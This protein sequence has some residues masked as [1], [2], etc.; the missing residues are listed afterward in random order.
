MILVES[1]GNHPADNPH[2][3]NTATK[4]EVEEK[5]QKDIP[6]SEMIGQKEYV[7]ESVSSTVSI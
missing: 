3:V 4:S 7:M 6:E 1:Y 5:F 2:S